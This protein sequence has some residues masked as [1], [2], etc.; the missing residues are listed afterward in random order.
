MEKTYVM[1]KP[2]AVKRGLIGEIISRIERKNLKIT[3]MKMFNLTEDILKEHYSHIANEPFFPGI[4]EF[5]VSGPV[6][7]MIVEGENAVYAVRQII[8]ATKWMEATPGT[9]RGDFASG[10]ISE[11]LIHASD[12]IESAKIEIARFFGKK[13]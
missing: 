1:L 3:D 5:M 6:V 9:I 13:S 8:G 10:S 4:V 11:N 12:S 2:D 7:G